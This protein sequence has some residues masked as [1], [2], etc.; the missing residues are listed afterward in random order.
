VAG[1][2]T[3]AAA[4]QAAT[5]N[6]VQA[7]REK[8]ETPQLVSTVDQ[9]RAGEG[10]A[11]VVLAIEGALDEKVGHNGVSAGATAKVPRVL[12]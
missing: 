4:G 1:G 10:P 5:S 9:A 12:P 6:A 7:V 11:T 3:L 8:S 2:E